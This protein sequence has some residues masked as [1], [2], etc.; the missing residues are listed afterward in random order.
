M[1]RIHAP[2]FQHFGIV[3]RISSG[4]WQVVI[5]VIAAFSAMLRAGNRSFK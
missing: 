5:Q 2:A 1:H 3:S 4:R